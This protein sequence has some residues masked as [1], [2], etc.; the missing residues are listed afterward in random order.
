MINKTTVSIIIPFKFQP[1][2]LKEAL[3]SIHRQ[4][5]LEK[6]NLE[7]IIIYEEEFNLNIKKELSKK[8][9]NI[10]YCLNESEEGPGGSRQTGLKVASGEFIIFL[11]SDDI[12]RPLFI[13]KMLKTLINNPLSSAAICFSLARFE[14]GFRI[15]NRIRLYPLMMIRDISLIFAY[16]FNK[17]NIFPTSFYLC[18]IS[19]MMFRVSA[20]KKLLFDY[21]YRRG[22]EDWDFFVKTLSHGSIKVTISRLLLFRYSPRSSTFQPLQLQNKWKSY[23]LLAKNLPDQF[24]KGLYY[25]LFLHYIKFFR[26]KKN[27]SI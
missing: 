11:D 20:I 26:R 21:Q 18:Q 27:A 2:F 6:I 10:R 13:I 9:P 25:Q 24:K 12:L 8:F 4:K 7:I 5:N 15:K 14:K 19:H 1:K 22:G 17:G 23:S 3:S 16:F